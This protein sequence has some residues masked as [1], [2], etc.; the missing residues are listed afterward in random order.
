MVEKWLVS[1]S[2]KDE[3]KKAERIVIR[4]QPERKR[5]KNMKKRKE[6]EEAEGEWEERKILL[7]RKWKKYNPKS[8]TKK[9][10]AK[11]RKDRKKE[12]GRKRWLRLF[13]LIFFILNHAPHLS[14]LYIP[15][16]NFHP[17]CIECSPFLS[18]RWKKR[19][20]REKVC[21]FFWYT[22]QL[23]R[24][25]KLNKEKESQVKKKKWNH[26]PTLFSL[27][28]LFSLDQESFVPKRESKNKKEG[29]RKSEREGG[30]DGDFLLSQFYFRPFFKWN[31]NIIQH[32]RN[33]MGGKK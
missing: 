23:K 21:L 17:L 13:I 29:E 4:Y 10:E 3:K 22:T 25:L 14:C 27:S 8:G 11:E 26:S 6:E 28:F 30:R 2:E 5:G 19:G 7:L 18:S 15:S 1:E 20:R 9:E 24:P 31:D 33:W 16:P 32:V 12:K